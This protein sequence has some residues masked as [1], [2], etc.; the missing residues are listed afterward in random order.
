V[1]NRTHVKLAL[2]QQNVAEARLGTDMFLSF[3]GRNIIVGHYNY[4][5]CFIFLHKAERFRSIYLPWHKLTHARDIHFCNG[6]VIKG[7][8]VVDSMQLCR[9]CK[10]AFSCG[11]C[12]SIGIASITIP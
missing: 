1:Q 9:G 4:L 10:E 8:S 6:P 5:R 7:A 12:S 11:E 3:P 2:S